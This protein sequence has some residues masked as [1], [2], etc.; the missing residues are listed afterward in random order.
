VGMGWHFPRFAVA[1]L[2]MASAQGLTS[3]VEA[4]GTWSEW[5]PRSLIKDQAGS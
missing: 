5:V 2:S 4:K 3:Q 1:A